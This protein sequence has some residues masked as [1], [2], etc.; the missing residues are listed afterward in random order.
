MVRRLEDATNSEACRIEVRSNLSL[1]LDRLAVVF[2]ALSGVTLGVALL[3][4]LMGYWPV[5]LFALIHLAIVGWCFRLAWRGHWAR[6]DIEIDAERIRIDSRTVREHLSTEWP[7]AWTRVERVLQHRELR[8]FL[9]LHR[10]RFEIGRFLPEAERKQA[11]DL[12]ADALARR[13][14]VV[15]AAATQTN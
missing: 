6:Q 1:T 15:D 5:L 10:Q 12:I 2:L 7:A 11:A 9:A 14:R 3:P 13:Y 8:V 4:T